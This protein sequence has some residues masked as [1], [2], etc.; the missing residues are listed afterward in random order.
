VEHPIFLSAVS[1]TSELL[2]SPA[3][4]WIG[5][6]PTKRGHRHPGQR[7]RRQSAPDL[8]S[9]TTRTIHTD[10]GRDSH[11]EESSQ[12]RYEKGGK[13]KV[14]PPFLARRG[15]PLR[16]PFFWRGSS[17]VC[18]LQSSV[19]EGGGTRNALHPTAS[20]DSGLTTV[21]RRPWTVLLRSDPVPDP[22]PPH[23]V[24]LLHLVDD[25]HAVHDMTEH[26]IPAV[27][28]WLR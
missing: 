8:A 9:K 27:E 22:D 28:V 1:P 18:G 15:A 7:A 19:I 21:D 13:E 2:L 24:P 4:T 26:G 23:D 6:W 11:G 14:G 5:S 12:G 20:N 16:R 17:A 10:E 25:L 3:P